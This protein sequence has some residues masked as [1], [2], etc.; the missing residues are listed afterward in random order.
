M[1]TIFASTE[2]TAANDDIPSSLLFLTTPDGSATATEKMRIQSDG[3]VGIGTTGPNATLSIKGDTEFLDGDTGLRI[4]LL[5]DNGTEGVFELRDNN[6]TKTTLRTAGASYF[7]GGSVGIGTSSPDAKLQVSGTAADGAELV[8]IESSGDVT[9]GGYHWMTSEMATGQSFDANIIHLI[10]RAETSKNSGYFGFN[11]QSNGGDDNFV[12]I[13]GYSANNLLNITM[14]GSVG[15]GTTSPAAKLDVV[16]GHIRLDAGFSLQWDNSHE[17]IEQSDGHLEFFVNNGEQMT[18]DTNGL[19]IGTTSPDFNLHIEAASDPTIRI[20][21]TTNN[22]KLDLRAEDSTVLIRSTGNHSMRFDVNQTERMRLDTSGNLGIGTTDPDAHLH[23]KKSAG[24]TTVLTEVA[25]NSTIGYEIKKTGSTTQHWKIVDGQTVNGTLEFYD[26][27]DSLTRMAINGSGSVGIGTTSPS[28]KLSIGSGDIALTTGYGIHS[29]NA[30]NE[31][32]IYFSASTAGN[33]SN[34]LHFKTDGSE[35]MRIDASGNVGVGITSPAQKLHVAGSTLIQGALSITGDGSNAVTFTETGSGLMTIATADDFVVDAGGD[36]R[37]DADGGDVRLND[38]G[39]SIGRLGLE[40]GDLNLASEQQDYDVRIKGNDGGSIITAL[41]FDMSDAGTAIFNNKVG[42]GTA[43]PS[44]KLVVVNSDTDT[45]ATALLQN[46]STGDASLHFNISGRS[47]TIGIDNSDGDKFKIARN[48]GLGTTD[49]LTIDGDGNVG[50]G[51]TS[52]AAKLEV[53][54]NLNLETSG[55]DVGLWLH[56]TDA[57]EYRL[58]VDSNGL[59]NLRDQDAGVTRMAVKTDGNVGIGTTTPGYKLEVNGDFAATSKSFII[60]HPTK[61][62]KRLRY[63]SLEGPENGVYVRGRGDSDIIELPDYWTGL[64]HDDSITVQITAIGKNSEGG[65]RSYSVNNII[66]NKVY[67][68]T[69]SKDAI[70]EYFY[71]VYAERKDIEKLQ[72]EI[73]K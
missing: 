27:T 38:N 66:D 37:L 40:N 36:I 68:Y 69:D 22:S 59:L 57:R 34:F 17:R 52:P 18:L 13:G 41:Q 73:D 44:N 65:I 24:E 53:A 43:S 39:V 63:A 42:I 15:I 64:V 25:A 14:G 56:R 28:E 46:S 32:G 55:G 49:R 35:R 21:D 9:D 23:I 12:T 16:S 5:Y 30:G 47:Y 10:G 71:N 61:P 11:Y 1:A 6:V 26:A 48:N 70:Y 19:G 33:A 29:V 45:T 51:T 7:T 50:I 60:D 4:G 2:A 3:N 54:G 72:V 58:Y 20:Q 8:R 31:N 62:N 67:V